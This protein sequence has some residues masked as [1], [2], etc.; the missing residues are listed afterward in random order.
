MESS[1]ELSREAEGGAF[2]KLSRLR[3]EAAAR[4]GKTVLTDVFFTAPY[5]VMQPF[6]KKGGIQVMALAA[7]AGLM[8]GDRQEVSVRVG[9]GASLELTS[10][11][12]EKIHQMKAGHAERRFEAFVERGGSFC[13]RPQPVIPF[14][15][16]AF[17]SRTRIELEDESARLFMSDI[18]SC[19][20]AARG[21]RFA[22]RYYRSLTE[23]CRAGALVYRD[24]CRYEPALFGM[25]AL[26]M[27]EGYTHLAS[28]FIS[29]PQEPE[30]TLKEARALLE[31]EE[32]V[33]GAATLLSFGDIACRVFGERA[34]RLEEV[35]ERLEQLSGI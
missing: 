13:F 4:G 31:K 18:F 17:E 29:R 15:A 11:A 30:R 9:A 34:Q 7:S 23:I 16:S 3:L 27:F 26:G 2:G 6:P 32:D 33:E 19:G 24:N 21:E 8:E 28:V 20:R 22:F 25:E 5:K 1:L 14:A 12:Y 35:C 10:Q